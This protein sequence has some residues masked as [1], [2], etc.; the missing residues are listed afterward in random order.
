M[1]WPSSE[2]TGLQTYSPVGLNPALSRQL[3]PLSSSEGSVL[4]I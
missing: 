4:S 2:S 3:L 1:V